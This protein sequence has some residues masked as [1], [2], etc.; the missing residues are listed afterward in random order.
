MSL[1]MVLYKG[2]DTG[3]IPSTRGNLSSS[4]EI[5]SGSR[6]T[7]MH[8]AC[9]HCKQTKYRCEFEPGVQGCVRCRRG[10]FPCVVSPRKQRAARPPRKAT[11]N[12]ASEPSNI[13][14]PPRPSCMHCKRLMVKCEF[15]PDVSRCV[16]CLR[17]GFECVVPRRKGHRRRPR[18]PPSDDSESDTT[19]ATT[20]AQ[21]RASAQQREQFH[22]SQYIAS[23]GKARL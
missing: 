9:D 17:S 11:T 21:Q 2:S 13:A 6:A 20:S 16:R 8:R 23:T 4:G 22:L 5:L 7:A 18:P 1:Q 12:L 10:G 3:T 19:R 14:P 15:K